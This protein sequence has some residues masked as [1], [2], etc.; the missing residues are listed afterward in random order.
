MVDISRKVQYVL[1]QSQTRKHDCHWPGCN[2]QVPPA[3]WGCRVHWYML[4]KRLRD[5]IWDTYEPGQ[6]KNMTPNRDY[7]QVAKEVQEWI[8][9]NYN[10]QS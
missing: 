5:R 3:M 1:R 10:N 2:K 8:A 4:P 9:T 6:E 7:I